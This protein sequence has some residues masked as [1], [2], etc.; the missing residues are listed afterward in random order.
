MTFYQSY[1][2]TSIYEK[3]VDI[4]V[5]EGVKE[6]GAVMF[7]REEEAREAVK[8]MDGGFIDL[9]QIVV[10]LRWRRTNGLIDFSYG[11]LFIDIY[12][13]NFNY[14]LVSPC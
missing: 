7:K 8:A 14:H 13:I 2:P 11:K 9:Q 10:S 4:E 6:R 12:L 3:V 5:M 1:Y